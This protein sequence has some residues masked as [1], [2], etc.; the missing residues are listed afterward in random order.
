MDGYSRNILKI[1]ET[2]PDEFMEMDYEESN[3]GEAVHKS[4]ESEKTIIISD[5][6]DTS[7]SVKVILI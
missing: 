5:L 6:S 1:S 2:L 3:S 4:Y 7:D